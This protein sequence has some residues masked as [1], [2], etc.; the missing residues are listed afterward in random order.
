MNGLL[1]IMDLD[2]VSGVYAFGVAL[3]GLFAVSM[4][5]RRRLRHTEGQKEVSQ[6][7]EFSYNDLIS[8]SI[9]RRIKNLGHSHVHYFLCLYQDISLIALLMQHR[10][11]ST[12]M[13]Y[14]VKN[15][16]TLRLS[17]K[18]FHCRSLTGK[19]LNRSKFGPLSPYIT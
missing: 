16:K 10:R 6:N 7:S 12:N 18:S 3:S 4:L 17:R 15:Y 1:S 2:M 5:Y 14:T 11:Q 9:R 8:I 19:Q 13:N